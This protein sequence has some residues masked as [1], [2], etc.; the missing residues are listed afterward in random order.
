MAQGVLKKSTWE[1]D[2]PFQRK[3]KTKLWQECV[4]LVPR[5]SSKD[6]EETEVVSRA[7][8]DEAANDEDVSLVHDSWRI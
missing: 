5:L 8:E 7:E 1:A 4:Q 2:A 3:L 6:R